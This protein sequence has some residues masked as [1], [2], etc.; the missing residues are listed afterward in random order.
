MCAVCPAPLPA[1]WVSWACPA[2]QETNATACPLTAVGGC[3]DRDQQFSGSF[4]PSFPSGSDT[5]VLLSLVRSWYGGGGH[6]RALIA[7]LF[8]GN[9]PRPC[10]GAVT[11]GPLVLV[12]GASCQQAGLLGLSCVLPCQVAV[13]AV[14]DGGC[15]GVD[16]R[17]AG[18]YHDTDQLLFRVVA[19]CSTSIRSFTVNWMA[20]LRSRPGD[21]SGVCTGEPRRRNNRR[22]RQS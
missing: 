9:G 10:C 2:G 15:Y 4:E 1:G 20:V 21:S 17:L 18:Q 22:R 19:G 16:V 6:G 11:G 7:T 13:E 12:L 5:E 3:A 8:P 14:C